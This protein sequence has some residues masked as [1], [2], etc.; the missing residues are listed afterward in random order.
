MRWV[1]IAEEGC[2]G[3]GELRLSGRQAIEPAH[4]VLV[5]EGR[6]KSSA[7]RDG[8]AEWLHDKPGVGSS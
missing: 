6:L 7:S 2:L 3:G 5:L 8:I 4:A 1:R